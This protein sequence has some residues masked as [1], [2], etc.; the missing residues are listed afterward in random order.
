MKVLLRNAKIISFNSPF[1]GQS[2]DILIKNGIISAINDEILTD[3][4]QVIAIPGLH[5]SEGWTDCFADF[6]D[7]GFESKET[8]ASGS[9]AAAA[10]G[11]TGVML[12]PNSNPVVQGKSGVEYL[13]R[14]AASLPVSLY[15]IG[16]V[17]Q[18]CNGKELTEMYDMF[19]SG[20]VA[21][22]DGHTSIQSAGMLLKA[23]QYVLAF[24]GTVIQ[25]PGDN[26]VG[27]GGLM[28]EGIISTRLGLPGIPSLSEYIQ[29]ERDIA[30]AEYTGSKIHFTGVSTEKTLSLILNAK[31][32]GIKVSFSVTPYHMYFCD[33]DLLG[34]NTYLKVSPPLR[35]RSDMMSIRN[36]AIEGKVDFIAS[37]HHPQEW[38]AKT[39][40]F[41]Y[42]KTGMSNIECVFG[43]AKVCGI[44]VNTFVQMQTSN[45]KKIFDLPIYPITEG[46][47]A[48]LTLFDPGV[49]YQFEKKQIYSK[50]ENNA[51]IGKAMEGKTFGIINGDK[52]FLP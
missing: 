4:D 23:L 47:K 34:Y 13:I 39:C 21:F 5:V 35:K 48:D 17:T 50:S 52:V 33:E 38:D 22:S 31:E 2:K 15:P 46:T 10:G 26:S 49:S 42:A 51:F 36:A 12:L 43:V 6:S 45:I 30:L 16:A 1:N 19:R 32:S 37:H 11:F 18:N 8:L 29:V 27:V 25:L 3:V 7:P 40:E 24:N 41:E 9:S 20:A 44:D 28:N 14:S